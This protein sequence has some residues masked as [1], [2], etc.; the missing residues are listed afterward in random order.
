[1]RGLVWW[2]G[3]GIWCLIIGFCYVEFGPLLCLRACSG[4]GR[5]GRRFVDQYGGGHWWYCF[6][7][8]AGSY[9]GH[10]APVRPTTHTKLLTTIKLQQ[11][12]HNN[13]HKRETG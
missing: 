7:C 8:F 3:L 11:T 12:H 1:M 2:C 13:V 5:V 6:V 9:V 4:L 10:C